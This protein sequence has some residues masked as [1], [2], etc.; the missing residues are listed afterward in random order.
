[1]W[2]ASALGAVVLVAMSAVSSWAQ[3]SDLTRFYFGVRIGETNPAVSA[4]DVKGFSLGV[5]FDLHTGVEVA[6]DSFEFPLNAPG[7]GYIGEW[8]VF[9][10]AP[11]VRLRYPLL[12]R[13]LVPYFLAG[14]GVGI[15]QFNSRKPQGAG[16]Q[17]QKNA[18][19][20]LGEVGAGIEYFVANNVAVGFEAKYVASGNQSIEVEGQPTNQ[21]FSSFLVQGG[22]RMFYPETAP[23]PP[24]EA[25]GAFTRLYV[26]VRAGGAILTDTSIFPGTGTTPEAPAYFGVID[27]MFG[28]SAGA[29]F[30]QYLGVEVSGEGFE[31][32]LT[33]NGLGAIGEYAVVFLI[34]QL[35]LRYPLFGGRLQPYVLGGIGASYGE[36]N[37]TKPPG[38]NL[39]VNA[40]DWSWGASAGAGFDYFIMRNIALGAEAKFVTGPGHTF[41]V[42]DGPT[43][44]GTVNAFLFSLGLRVFLWDL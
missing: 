25:P 33:L 30:G 31:T 18:T 6:G 42:N 9:A 36:Y 43:Q 1:M 16:L 4:K 37:D 40:E 3:D 20:P 27:Q 12:G 44:K 11:E 34:P 38:F 13:R 14:V 17:I 41:Q 26:G 5:N 7:Y 39:R 2:A 35:R 10:L 23:L 19:W 28:I 24:L 8:A 21:N 29:N 15:G 32:N 22:M